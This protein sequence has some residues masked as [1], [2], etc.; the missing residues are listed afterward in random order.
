MG[1]QNGEPC[2]PCAMRHVKVID[3]RYVRVTDLGPA[4]AT[5]PMNK[6][7]PSGGPLAGQGGDA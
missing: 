3:G 6:V 2:C 4:P 1:P 5:E 7:F